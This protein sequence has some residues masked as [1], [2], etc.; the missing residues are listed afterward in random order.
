M[1]RM[2]VKITADGCEVMG[3]QGIVGLHVGRTGDG[4]G[5]DMV[6]CAMLRAPSTK[7]SPLEPEAIQEC[8]LLESKGDEKNKK[9]AFL[10]ESCRCGPLKVRGAIG[11]EKN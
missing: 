10:R 2:G 9:C 3:Y 4:I 8:T 11:N 6:E 1:Q 5:I 7:A